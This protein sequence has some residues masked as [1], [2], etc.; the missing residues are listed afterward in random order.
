MS[1]PVMTRALLSAEHEDLRESFGRYLDAEIVPHYREWERAGR[2][3]AR[4]SR[5]GRRARIPGLC[6]WL[7]VRR[8]GR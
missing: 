5:A 6:G 3:P 8:R 4:G 1:V 2:I 7:R